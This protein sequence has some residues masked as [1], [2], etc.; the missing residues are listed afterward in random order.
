MVLGAHGIYIY[1]YIICIFICRRN[2]NCGLEMLRVH[3]VAGF[4]SEVSIY[5]ELTLSYTKSKEPKIKSFFTKK[6]SQKFH[7]WLSSE[8]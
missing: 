2:P 7:I 4:L 1:I 3:I 6:D 5:L 8:Y